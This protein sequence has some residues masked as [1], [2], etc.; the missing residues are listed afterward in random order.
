MIKI[1]KQLFFNVL[2]AY[3]LFFFIPLTAK[4]SEIQNLDGIWFICEYSISNDP[5]DDNC[6]ML[7]NDGFLV[8]QGK[9]SHL[10]IKNSNFNFSKLNGLNFMLPNFKK[11]PLLKILKYKFNSTYFEIILVTINDTLVKNYLD[12][13]IAYISI[14]KIMLKLLK[15]R[16]LA[17]FFNT[18][19]KNINE[20]KLMVNKVNLY[21]KKYI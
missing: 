13:K 11:F 14:H 3:C 19:P 16:Y 4:S 2:I 5:P 18:S 10:K 20:I 6:E 9:I 15:K 8:E 17:K 21:L 7:D 12:S 1:N